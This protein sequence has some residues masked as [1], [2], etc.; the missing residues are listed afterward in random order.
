MSSE[1]NEVLYKGIL[2]KCGGKVKTWN[3][4]AMSLKADYCLYYYKDANTKRHQ[5]L[6]SLRDPKFAVRKG[7]KSDC[8][9]PK[10]VDINNTLV[11]VTTPRTYYMFAETGEEA[12]EW[13]L[14]LGMAHRK[15]VS[16]FTLPREAK[17]QTTAPS[18][19]SEQPSD[20]GGAGRAGSVPKRFQK[21]EP[22][23][24]TKKFQGGDEKDGDEEN[25]ELDEDDEDDPNRGISVSVSGTGNPKSDADSGRPAS[26]SDAPKR[27]KKDRHVSN[28][29]SQQ[30]EEEED[31]HLMGMSMEDIREPSS[32]AKSDDK[33]AAQMTY[34]EVEILGKTENYEA[35]SDSV[36]SAS[37]LT[38]KQQQQQVAASSHKPTT[39]IYE[40]IPGDKAG[41]ALYEDLE[42]KGTSAGKSPSLSRTAQGALPPPTSKP[43]VPLEESLY[44]NKD[45]IPSGLPDATYDLIVYNPEQA[46]QDAPPPRPAKPN[47][48]NAQTQHHSEEI[49]YDIIKAEDSPAHAGA[50]HTFHVADLSTEL[51]SPVEE[52]EA[53]YDDTA[54]MSVV[55][56][57]SPPPLPQRSPSM[58]ARNTLPHESPK[59][60]HGSQSPKMAKDDNSAPSKKPTDLPKDHVSPTPANTSVDPTSD[61]PASPAPVSAPQELLVPSGGHDTDSTN[62]AGISSSPSGTPSVTPPASNSPA[63]P[64]PSPLP[65]RSPQSRAA[66]AAASVCGQVAVSQPCS[67]SSEPHELMPEGQVNTQPAESLETGSAS[68][69]DAQFNVDPAQS[70][71]SSSPHATTPDNRG[72]QQV[73]PNEASKRQKDSPRWPPKAVTAPATGPEEPPTSPQRT[74]SERL[75]SDESQATSLFVRQQKKFAERE[76]NLA[77]ERDLNIQALKTV[78]NDTSLTSDKKAAFGELLRGIE[79]QKQSAS[80]EKYK[81]D[82]EKMK[83]EAERQKFEEERRRFMEERERLAANAAK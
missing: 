69:V 71:S 65:P 82:R 14:Q 13:R 43:T 45:P 25:I 3:K 49:L 57:D 39:L 4:R 40:E 62:A 17:A 10:G 70:S 24:R 37:S 46:E 33:T 31:G 21:K 7:E 64:S 60:P 59:P 51:Q 9:W 22:M 73:P 16:G 2:S 53:F 72:T 5:G 20:G 41:E 56:T 28:T 34:E 11:V 19:G 15:M 63:P 36:S 68:K 47:A 61:H 54:N 76:G 52:N 30:D 42:I 48:A 66:V 32:V 74:T 44:D 29:K 78:L 27:H 67:P 58:G 38:N 12:D 83:F 1:E 80:E 50:D 79:Q 55:K 23:R 77:A 6:I 81:L 35:I 8:S 75:H 26:H 18:T